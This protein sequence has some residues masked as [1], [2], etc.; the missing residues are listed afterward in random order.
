[1]AT[2]K[3]AEGLAELGLHAEAWDTLDSLPAVERVMP[4]ALRV[5]ID[6][7]S[8]VNAWRDCMEI[9]KFLRHGADLNRLAAANFYL[10]LARFCVEHDELA[11]AKE[12]VRDFVDTLP[13]APRELMNNPLVK[14]LL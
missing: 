2:L 10:E 14:L 7:R 5:R 1:M 4:S 3:E 12:A 9:A 13:D 8:H 11:A 6:C